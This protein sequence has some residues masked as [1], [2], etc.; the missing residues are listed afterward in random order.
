VG[1]LNNRVFWAVEKVAIKDN[2]AA[3]TNQNAPWNAKEFPSGAMAL[4]LDAD[5]V[6]SGVD[7][8]N[9]RWEIARGVQ[10]VT[11]TTAFN[12]EQVFELG[13]IEIYEDS[14]RVPDVDMT[15]EKVL[16]GTKMM[17]F[18]CSNPNPGID[19]NY[20]PRLGLNSRVG[21]FRADIGLSIYDDTQERSTGT[22][23]SSM[24][25]SGMYL[26]SITYAFP[27]D[28]PCTESLTFVGNDK[29]WANY[30]PNITGQP[31]KS[32][33]TGGQDDIPGSGYSVPVSGFEMPEATQ[34]TES[35]SLRI[36]GSGIQRRE[37][38]DMRRTVLPSDIPGIVAPTIVTRNASVVGGSESGTVLQTTGNCGNMIERIQTIT[39]SVDLNR[40]DAGE[41]GS[42]RPYTRYINFPIETSA[43]IEVLTSQGDMVEADAAVD[44]GPDNTAANQTVIVRTID[45]T[46]IDL[47]DGMRLQGVDF[48]PGDAGGDNATVTYN[49]RGFNVFNITH[50]TFYP[51]HRIYLSAATGTRFNIGASS[52]F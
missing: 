44:I 33:P 7:Q 48:S 35:A 17:Y 52:T 43:A 40:E 37:D 47:G 20:R 5:Y 28:G 49:Y 42:K 11:S 31:V 21:N 15:I 51:H 19:S 16:D 12:L 13:Q 14:E 26:S 23:R 2:S 46:Q 36:I 45:G 39:L 41:L 3:S 32:F 25:A 18:M 29:L 50:D 30:N 27:I 38:V 4:H 34:G 10:S 1:N 24:V 9:G 6:L 22:P 8:V